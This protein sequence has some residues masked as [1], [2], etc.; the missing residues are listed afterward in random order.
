M[1]QLQTIADNIP[2]GLCVC[3]L[4]DLSDDRTL[5]IVFANRAVGAGTGL[6]PASLVGKSLDECFPCLRAQGIPQLLADVVRTQQPSRL[7]DIT[8]GGTLDAP[9]VFSLLVFPLPDNGV[10][11]IFQDITERKRQ[12]NALKGQLAELQRW[13]ELTL[14][15]EDRVIELKREVDAL[16]RRLGEPP[17]YANEE[18]PAKSSTPGVALASSKASDNQGQHG[19]PR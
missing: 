9:S 18:E 17:H 11:V 5:S 4:D 10:G 2:V 16:L 14:D 6:D 19:G 12:E 8:D 15:R 7:S 13:Y 3:R 1:L